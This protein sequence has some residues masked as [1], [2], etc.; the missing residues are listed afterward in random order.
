MYQVRLVLSVLIGHDMFLVV[1]ILSRCCP[2]SC[3]APVYEEPDNFRLGVPVKYMW[4]RVVICFPD[5][6]APTNP[7]RRDIPRLSTNASAV[8]LVGRVG[9]WCC[10]LAHH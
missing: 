4:R 6:F 3:P 1:L 10:G 9:E 2:Q 7:G 5:P 8:G